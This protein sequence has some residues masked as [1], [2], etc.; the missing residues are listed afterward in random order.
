MPRKLRTVPPLLVLALTPGLEAQVR[1]P[2]PTAPV[3][4]VTLDRSTGEPLDG[5]SVALAPLPDGDAPAPPA[6]TDSAG[7]FSFDPEI[8][9]D[10]LYRISF[11]RL[12][13][14]T[15][16]DTV[17]FMAEVGLELEAQ[18]VPRA[19]ELEP[20]LV[21]TEGRNR[22]LER[23]GFYGRRQRGVGRFLTR[24]QLGAER[25]LAASEMFRR[26]PGVRVRTT[27]GFPGRTVLTMRNGCHPDV[28]LDGARTHT[29]FPVDDVLSPEMVDAV[30]I[31]GVSQLPARFGNTQ[32]GAVLVW[33]RTPNA[34]PAQPWGW[35]RFLFAVGFVVGAVLL[36]R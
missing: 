29:P 26:I 22:S 10:G 16:S 36:T 7:R 14:V 28:Y 11:Q 9:A 1:P 24:E 3:F 21:V 34:S 23:Q 32:C 25:A 17:P 20:L 2:A 18:L 27:G 15:L 35:G 33:T 12:G 5:V 6:V 31:Y 4:G 30:E 8:M 19:L 13:Y